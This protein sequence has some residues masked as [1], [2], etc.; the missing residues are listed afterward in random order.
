MYI[1]S[2]LE[3]DDITAWFEQTSRAIANELL[4][5]QSFGQLFPH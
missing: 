2:V 1:Y 3:A 4:H 5:L